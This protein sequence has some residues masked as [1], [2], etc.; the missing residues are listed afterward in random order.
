[1][2]L[3]SLMAQRIKKSACNAGDTG[4][5]GTIPGSGRSPGEGKCQATP[6]CL[7]GKSHGQRSLTGYSPKGRKESETTEGWSAHSTRA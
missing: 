2:G 6:V 4:D 7:P 1:M 5:V 3:P